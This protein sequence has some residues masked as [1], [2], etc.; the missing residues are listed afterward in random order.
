MPDL[1]LRA[2]Q[3]VIIVIGDARGDGGAWVVTPHGLKRVPDNNPELHRAFEAVVKNYAILEKA[4][5][6]QK[7]V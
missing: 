7:T 4:V 1:D 3:K 6:E 5:Q 2:E